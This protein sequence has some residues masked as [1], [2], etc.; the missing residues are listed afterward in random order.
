VPATTLQAIV[1]RFQAVCEGT[2][3][4]LTATEQPFSFDTQPNAALRDRYWVEDRGVDSVEELTSNLEVRRDR[5]AIWIARPLTPDGQVDVE[6]MQTTALTI[7]RRLIADG[8]NNNYYPRFTAR[9]I[10]K[11]DDTDVAI[12][13][14]EFL[15]DYD[16][17]VAVV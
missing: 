2:G 16:V 13:A 8:P 7:Q 9:E 10:S 12:M 1:D 17:S 11:V 14:I 15:V 5:L 6:S 3:V 4:S